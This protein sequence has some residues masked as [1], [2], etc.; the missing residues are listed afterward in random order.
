MNNILNSIN[1]TI[2]AGLKPLVKSEKTL[3]EIKEQAERIV[4]SW[5]GEDKTFQCD[6]E[7]YH[8]EDAETA[9]DL[10]EAIKNVEELLAT[11]NI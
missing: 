3:S 8:E 9:Q 5:N 2:T 1:E 11:L 4:S 6:G 10:I 7:T